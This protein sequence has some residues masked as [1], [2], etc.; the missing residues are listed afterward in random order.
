MAHPRDG[1][2]CRHQAR[3]RLAT[4]AQAAGLSQ[5][6]RCRSRRAGPHRLQERLQLLPWRAGSGGLSV[7]GRRDRQGRSHRAARHRQSAPRQLHAGLPAKAAHGTVRRYTLCLQILRKDRRL[8][9]SPAR[10]PVAA[11]PLSAQWCRSHAEGS[12]RPA[13]PAARSLSARQR[14]DRW[15]QWRL[16]LAALRSQGPAAGN[17]LLLRHHPDRQR[18]GWP[19]LRHGSAGIRQI[20][21]TFLSAHL[22]TGRTPP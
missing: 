19:S 12:A 20:G 2:S 14:R 11:R 13:C 16:P 9:Q 3:C 15:R 5:P 4:H 1:R 22:L 17:R 21:S 18:Q 8:R 10:W 7:P 6:A